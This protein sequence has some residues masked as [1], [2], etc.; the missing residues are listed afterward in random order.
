MIGSTV[1]NYRILKHLAG[2][3][4]FPDG[5]KPPVLFVA[6]DLTLRKQYVLKAIGPISERDKKFLAQ[7]RLEVE[8]VRHLNATRE[9][10]AYVVT[11]NDFV[12]KTILHSVYEIKKTI[13]DYQETVTIT[14]DPGKYFFIVMEYCEAGD[15]EDYAKK[16]GGC[17][18]I[19]IGACLQLLI[20]PCKALDLVHHLPVLKGEEGPVLHLDVKP[21]NLLVWLGTGH[22]ILKLT[23]F[24]IM[25]DPDGPTLTSL[26]GTPGYHAP[27]CDLPKRW[28]QATDLFSLG[29]TAY[30]MLTDRRILVPRGRETYR[31]LLAERTPIPPMSQF[32]PD[33]RQ[34]PG[35][36]SLVM[37]MLE[38]DP[39][40]RPA[41]AMEVHQRLEKILADRSKN[42]QEAEMQAEVARRMAAQRGQAGTTVPRKPAPP[43]KRIPSRWRVAA[44][45]A[46]VFGAALLAGAL[47][48]PNRAVE[49]KAQASP[50]VAPPVVTTTTPAKSSPSVSDL[51]QARLAADRAEEN[52]RLEQQRRAWLTAAQTAI[53]KPDFALAEQWIESL[54]KS[55]ADVSA[56]SEELRQARAKREEEAEAARRRESAGQRELDRERVEREAKRTK[57]GDLRRAIDAALGRGNLVE[58]EQKAAELAGID[59]AEGAAMQNKIAQA[60]AAK[61]KTERESEEARR[62]ARQLAKA[63]LQTLNRLW[64]QTTEVSPQEL[65]ARLEK[66]KKADLTETDQQQAD[67]FSI[68]LKAA[69]GLKK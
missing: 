62:T 28:C 9:N 66:I 67:V 27:E 21:K 46:V 56:V 20:G 52:A 15:L 16:Q 22:A 49:V 61:A 11:V 25:Y 58:A 35:L 19:Q 37:Q 54:R 26:F 60:K 45:A 23:D 17:K 47:T 44:G 4:P 63:E 39:S 68:R 59:A 48:W 36:E 3:E 14:I 6:E 29:A 55:G 2:G 64:N 33:V 7:R 65:L 53:R 5:R 41:T 1:G 31:E 57:V 10:S 40:N 18:N 32:R 24:G 13:D 34:W 42:D 51:R 12:E 43:P 38:Y 69:I 8:R 30:W 50:A